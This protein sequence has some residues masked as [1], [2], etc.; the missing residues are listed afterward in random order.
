[1]SFLCFTGLP[2]P[3]FI[4]H[5]DPLLFLSI[6]IDYCGCPQNGICLVGWCKPTPSGAV[7]YDI[8]A[9]GFS[10]SV[11]SEPYFNTMSGIISLITILYRCALSTTSCGLI[12][13]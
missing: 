9:R 4:W 13:Q 7:G 3:S 1:G 2:A 6:Q 5:P 11:D 12:K 10:L 8:S